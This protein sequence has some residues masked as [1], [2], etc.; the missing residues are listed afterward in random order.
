[1]SAAN[2]IF[3][4]TDSS[5]APS[6]LSHPHGQGVYLSYS[7][8]DLSMK[9]SP[10]WL[11]SLLI[12]L[13][14]FVALAQQQGLEVGPT[15]Q[16]QQAENRQRLLQATPEQQ[17]Q[18]VDIRHQRAAASQERRLAQEKI[19]QLYAMAITRA[20][21]TR[22]IRP[23]SVPLGARCPVQINQ[24]PGGEVIDLRILPECS[25]DELGKKSVEAAILKVQ[26]LPYA[27][28]ESVFRRTVMFT[29]QAQ[30]L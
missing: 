7:H 13:L 12:L 21:E 3:R 30:N 20:I 28:F 9:R 19:E 10:G 8:W 15:E 24:I 6:S 2:R 18:L 25:Y 14:S 27:G 11:A 4:E 23:A 5:P 29:F 16:D 17:Q 22:W 26:P 1:M